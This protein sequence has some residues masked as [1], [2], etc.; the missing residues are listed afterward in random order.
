[1]PRLRTTRGKALHQVRRGRR[2]V[3]AR[4]FNQGVRDKVVHA[5]IG[6]GPTGCMRV[7]GA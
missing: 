6:C 2:R 4:Q 1:M 3:T 7:W 5:G